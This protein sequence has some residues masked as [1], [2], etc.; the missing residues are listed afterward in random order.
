[1]DY[2]VTD[3][4]LQK[5]IENTLD[6]FEMLD[7]DNYLRV[8]DDMESMT[9]EELIN[10]LINPIQ[11]YF[12]PGNEIKPS[13]L[14]K[15]ISKEKIVITEPVEMKHI[16]MN[17]DG[18]GVITRKSLTILPLYARANQQ[19]AM[20]EGKAASENIT[21]NIAGQV[22]GKAAKSG[23]FS[24]AE[25]TVTIGH[26]VNNIMRELMGPASHDLVSKKEMKQSIIKTGEVSLKNLTD[27]AENKKS[28]R[29]FAEILKSMDI[30]TDLVE[31]PQRW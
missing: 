13:I 25:L 19:I 31:P 9:R 11:V 24:D 26:D 15:V 14:D 20:K 8:K 30:D 1:M 7:P 12:D 22:T 23:Q 6:I 10:F 16:S 28:L 17:K 4:E 27:N 5:S 29:Y 3:E 21:R 18:K 2:S